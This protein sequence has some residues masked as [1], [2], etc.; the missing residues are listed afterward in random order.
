[1]NLDGQY[2]CEPW[3]YLEE[4]NEKI[5]LIWPDLPKWLVIDKE[6]FSFLK[7]I[8]G[9]KNLDDIIKELSKEFNKEFSE[10]KNELETI[11]PKLVESRL[12]YEKNNRPEPLKV[13]EKLEDVSVNVT[14][15][16]N[17]NCKMCFNRFNRVDK[18]SELSIDEIKNFLDQILEFCTDETMISISGGEAL[19]VPE[20]TIA[21]A[22]YARKLGFKGIAV[23]TNG[24]L[25]T[26]KFAK[27]AKELNLRVMVSLDGA[28]EKDHDFIRGKGVFKKA[29]E[30]IRL[31][32]KYDNFVTTNYMVHMGNYRTLSDYYKLAKELGVNKARFISFKRMGSGKDE[33]S[34]DVV[35]IDKL[36]NTSYDLFINHPEFRDLT[37][38]DLLTAFASQCRL[39]VKRG[40]CGT[41][42]TVVLL[43]ADGSIYPCVGHTFPEFKAGNIREKTFKEIWH[44]SPILKKIRQIYD[45][46]NI[47]EECSKCIVKHWCLSCRSEAY[48]VSG[49]LN[50]VDTQCDRRKKAIIE[51]FWR[52]AKHPNLGKGK[53]EL[54]H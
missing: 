48:Q 30:G 9:K 33:S 23:L 31:L 10:V 52:L 41:G 50:S 40:W 5:L 6:L 46:D 28:N 22:E 38:I 25:V 4:K 12:I 1:M 32:K 11:I 24:T 45:V 3:L 21:V 49:K 47:N 35:P 34:L 51:M 43:D 54:A 44:G 20:K 13:N 19:L 2:S 37:G 29:I 7:K 53:V 14:T 16:C 15:R 17:L 36:V 39:N 27:K 42:K 8:D 26:E 18:V